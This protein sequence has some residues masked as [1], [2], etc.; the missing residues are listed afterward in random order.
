MKKVENIL[1]AFEADEM[2]K[3]KI[4]SASVQAIID[5]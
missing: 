5:R 2:F 4:Q 3:N 1:R